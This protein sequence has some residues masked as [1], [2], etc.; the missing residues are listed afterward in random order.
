MVSDDWSWAGE[1]AP[2]EAVPIDHGVP[3]AP[4]ASNSWGWNGEKYPGGWGVDETVFIDTLLNLDYFTLRQRSHQL[5]ETNLYARGVIR[6]LI[7]NEVNTG[8]DLEARPV[9]K[10]LD[11]TDEALHEWSDKYRY[12]W[13]RP[14]P[15][16]MVGTVI[17][18]AVGWSV[19]G[20]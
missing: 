18:L 6:R 19:G 7:T 1:D 15:M 4:K 13:Q 17:G 11:T 12:W 20:V 14:Q 9:A 5:F 16:L 2:A 10:M 3:Y 8:L